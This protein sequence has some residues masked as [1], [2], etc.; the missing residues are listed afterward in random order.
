MKSLENQDER[1]LMQKRKVHN[2]AF[3]LLIYYLLIAIV[4]QKV[5]F[6]A[7][8]YQIIVELVGVVG[9][10][11]YV[12]IRNLLLGRDIYSTNTTIIVKGSIILGCGCTILL[13][14]MAGITDMQ[15]L[16]VLFLYTTISFASFSFLFY[17]LNRKK[18]DKIEEEL[19]KDEDDIE[20]ELNNDEV[21]IEETI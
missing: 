11:F 1:I 19:N 14:I 10:S 13:R 5:I 4:V 3:Q 18:Q 12:E 7:P 17:Y 20:E 15:I 9:A 2:E 16:L 8:F 6:N 21:D